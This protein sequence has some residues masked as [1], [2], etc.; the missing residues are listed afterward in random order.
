MLG[1]NIYIHRIHFIECLH[2][3]KECL[4]GILQCAALPIEEVT[5]RDP[6][7]DEQED[8]EEEENTREDIYN[9]CGETDRD[10]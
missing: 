7:H 4:K 5:I 9:G 8:E 6:Q 10:I 2:M 3:L 1:A